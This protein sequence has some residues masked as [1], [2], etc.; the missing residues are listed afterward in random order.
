MIVDKGCGWRRQCDVEMKSMNH[1]ECKPGNRTPASSL[2]PSHRDSGNEIQLKG[3][4]GVVEFR[5]IREK[6]LG[7]GP[8]IRCA[9]IPAHRAKSH[10]PDIFA[11]VCSHCIRA[12]K[13]I[14]PTASTYPVIQARVSPVILVC[15][16]HSHCYFSL[17]DGQVDDNTCAVSYSASSFLFLLFFVNIP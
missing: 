12:A 9:E 10:A 7:N 1:R 14:P 2:G 3:K 16:S 5:L 8:V 11:E 4:Q 15:A 17:N 6:Q 13:N